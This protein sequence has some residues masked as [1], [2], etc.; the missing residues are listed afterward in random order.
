MKQFLWIVLFFFIGVHAVSA[1]LV[2]ESKESKASASLTDK[3][4]KL[5][6]K[7]KNTSDK[8]IQIVSGKASCDCMSLVTKFP[9]SVLPGKEVEIIANYDT[10]GKVGENRG[11]VLLQSDEEHIT[12]LVEVTI[13]APVTMSS[14]FLIWKKDE[15]DERKIT[16]EAH[17]DWKGSIDAANSGDAAVAAKLVKTSTGYELLVTPDESL[18]KKRTWVKLP[19]KDHE[20]KAYEY[21]IFLIFN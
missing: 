18:P 7:A 4:V 5:T 8:E 15:R 16:I 1:E 12:L 21:S 9:F 2:W 6:F 3:L 17:P 14:R 20:G 11:R 10:T 13:P 19:G